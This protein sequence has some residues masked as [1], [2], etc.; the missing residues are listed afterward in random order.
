MANI[1]FKGGGFGKKGPWKNFIRKNDR[2]KA[3]EVRVIGS[4]GKQL[5]V[6]ET[7][8]AVALAKQ[9]GLDLVEVS[10]SASPPVCKIVDFGKYKYDEGKKQKSGK[11][12]ASKIKE[13]K[14]RFCTEEHDYQTKLRHVLDFL[15]DGSKVKIG[16]AFRGREMDLTNLGFDLIKKVVE[17]VKEF[18]VPDGEPRLTGRMVLLNLSPVKSSK[19]KIAID[20]KKDLNN[21]LEL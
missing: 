14:F 18:G 11:V 9:E 15:T 7:A 8:T 17:D 2:I 10:A 13:V 5:G 4:D 12:A 3:K 1:S 20:N 19:K 6:M 16:V 21:G